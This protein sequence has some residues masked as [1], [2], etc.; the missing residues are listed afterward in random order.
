[1][2]P[3]LG[4]GQLQFHEKKRMAE[5]GKGDHRLKLLVLTFL[6]E[7]VGAHGSLPALV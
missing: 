7:G 5:A 2:L 1:M 6:A 4:P 3:S